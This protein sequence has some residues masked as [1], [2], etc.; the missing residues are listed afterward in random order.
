MR[1]LGKRAVSCLTVVMFCSFGFLSLALT[2]V[3]ANTEN[4]VATNDEYQMNKNASDKDVTGLG[5]SPII[6][7]EYGNGN[8]NKVWYGSG[9]APLRFNVLNV[10]ETNMSQGKVGMLLDC[11]SIVR[12][13][14]KAMNNFWLYEWHKS[15][16]A[17]SV[18]WILDDRFDEPERSGGL[19]LTPNKPNKSETDG[20]DIYISGNKKYNYTDPANNWSKAFI[21]DAYEALNPTYG[22]PTTEGPSPLRKKAGGT[23]YWLR[24]ENG[25]LSQSDYLG[26]VSDKSGMGLK[27]DGWNS[28]S[29]SGVSPAINL[30]VS[31]VLFSTLVSGEAG[32]HNAEYKL[33][34][35][36]DYVECISGYNC[37]DLYSFKI[38]IPS[39]Q[40]VTR[41]GRTIT[42]PFSILG[43]I[44]KNSITQISML[45][46]SKPW[47]QEGAQILS[48]GKLENIDGD[49]HSGGTGTYTVPDD[50]GLYDEDVGGAYVY[51]FA[52][53]IRDGNK[54]DHASN[55]I[56]LN[57]TK[58]VRIDAEG[59]NEY[60]DGAEH[61]ITVTP[62]SSG[63]VIKYGLSEGTY[64]LDESPKY[65]DAGTNVRVYYEATLDGRITIRDS[66]VIEINKRPIKI[67]GINVDQ[68]EYDGTTTSTLNLDEVV[69]DGLIPGD[70]LS[71]TNYSGAFVDKNVSPSQKVGLVYEL[72]GDD[73]SNYVL[74][75]VNSQKTA[76]AN[77][78][79]RHIRV[80]GI[81][82][83]PKIWDGTTNARLDYSDVVIDR[84]IDGD[85]LYITATGEF[86]TPAEG[87]NK[88][89]T[90]NDLTL[91]GSDK[92]NYYLEPGEQQTTAEG[93]ISAGGSLP[94]VNIPDES[95]STFEYDSTPHEVA[96]TAE[97]TV[98]NPDPNKI[99]ILYNDV[100]S[101]THPGWNKTPRS[102]ADAGTK[103][104]YFNVIDQNQGYV[105]VRGSFLI[106][107]TPA[108]LAV[109]NNSVTIT[110]KVYDGTTSASPVLETATFNNLKGEDG[111]YLYLKT[112]VAEFSDKNVGEDKEVTLS[113][114][115]LGD[116]N[117]QYPR[118]G[119]YK[120]NN[121][122]STKGTITKR[123][124]TISGLKALNKTYDANNTATIDKENIIIDNLI[125]NDEISVNVTGVYDNANAGDNKTVTL[126]YELTGEDASNYYVDELTSQM[127]TEASIYKKDLSI[128]ENNIDVEY[129]G[130][131]HKP[132]VSLVDSL[133][134]TI[135]YGLTEDEI[136]LDESPE[137]SDAGIN[138]VYYRITTGDAN[139]SE[140]T[141]TLD[142]LI[143]SRGLVISGIKASDK[144]YD[145]TTDVALNTDGLKTENIL[146]GDD[147]NV[148]VD[149]SFEDATTGDNKKVNLRYTLSGEDADNYTIDENDSEISTVASIKELAITE[150]N[151]QTFTLGS[152][153]N[154]KITCSGELSELTVIKVND[155]IL[156]ETNYEL[157]SGSTALTLK[158]SYL[159]TLRVGTY[160]V[161]F[162]YGS[163]SV[164]AI[165]NVADASGDDSDTDNTIY[166]V[167]NTGMNSNINNSEANHSVANFICMSVIV[168]IC[169][170]VGIVYA[171]K[172]AIYYQKYLSEK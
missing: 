126:V 145:G 30:D 2:T 64:D 69:Y 136:T 164:D 105:E 48:Y 140:A 14:D 21:L 119:N 90:I 50:I 67:S 56:K 5:I 146:D 123:P 85:D 49:I 116:N 114:L 83:Y 78:Y 20:P 32:T 109:D 124:L 22:F 169:F 66:K 36:D 3:Y 108:P 143:R 28:D 94:I 137:F 9:S 147:V 142:V 46:T 13:A 101:P 84:S 158:N 51:L 82:V 167:P 98:E 41:S 79:Q 127:N 97:S 53:S 95:D 7:P 74:D 131:T 10:H 55:L 156:D 139:Y 63:T 27:S 68:K 99:T 100:E 103:K 96:I 161:T 122:A 42:V 11:D 118:R 35:I 102:Q 57:F 144:I 115:T 89:V 129:D 25:N 120:L 72:T 39:G 107:V 12:G 61:G 138:N 76:K 34:V 37:R 62:Y 170:I 163:N 93:A 133:D 54:P 59:Y 141:G 18:K 111:N 24:S 149:G 29:R 43:G 80:S 23:E 112:A 86:D 45:I 117:E 135:K 65:K 160:K 15:D 153:N 91:N 87:T 106:R 40:Q 88:L 155:D 26:Y 162:E 81:K 73:I 134:A 58:D 151:N 17:R 110:S 157:A 148:S 154:I 159:N 8:W 60:Y 4:E 128:L 31:K 166:N 92:N 77:I 130:G 33:T 19:L 168:V 16:L 70:N 75:N 121:T 172:M 113:G 125:E 104:V 171:K 47:N 152:T 6:N 150:G 71:L 132:S 52:E 38:G 1:K 44:N 165:L